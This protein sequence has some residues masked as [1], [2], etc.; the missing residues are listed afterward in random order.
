MDNHFRESD[1]QYNIPV[2]MGLI[3]IW[4]INFFKFPTYCVVPYDQYLKRFPAYLQQ[5]DMES[6][7]KFVT[8]HNEAI[9]YQT[10][11]IV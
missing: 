1:F 8:K 2:L 3:G 4:Y 6:N 5:L 10:G 9:N 11:P 7:G